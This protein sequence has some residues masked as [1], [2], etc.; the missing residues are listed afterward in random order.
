MCEGDA[1]NLFLD[2]SRGANV[3]GCVSFSVRDGESTTD[4][5]RRG[6]YD[7][8]LLW[9]LSGMLLPADGLTR[10]DDV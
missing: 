4:V 8:S 5:R 1:V 7:R 9:D 6:M 2:S 10:G 3:D